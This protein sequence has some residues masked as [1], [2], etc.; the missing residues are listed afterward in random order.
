LGSPDE[1]EL[2]MAEERAD[3]VAIMAAIIYAGRTGE[4]A[5]VPKESEFGLIAKAAWDL[6]KA[7]VGSDE[8]HMGRAGFQQP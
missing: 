8:V 1:L 3:V 4:S 7:V 6:H 5:Q 2:E